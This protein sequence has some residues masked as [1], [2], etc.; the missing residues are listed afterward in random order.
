MPTRFWEI[1]KTYA[2][3]CYNNLIEY[4]DTIILSRKK[5]LGGYHGHIF[6]NGFSGWSHLNDNA[7][8]DVPPKP[9]HLRQE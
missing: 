5:Q 7:K 2:L 1:S 9:W 6:H 8:K 3:L 4:L